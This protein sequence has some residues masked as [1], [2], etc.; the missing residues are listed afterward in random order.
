M[1]KI[2]RYKDWL[3]FGLI[4]LLGCGLRY[5]QYGQFPIAG[6]TLDEYAWS[7]L[8]ASL[9]EQHYPASWSAFHAYSQKQTGYFY[10][11][12]PIVA[13]SLDHPPLFAFLPGFFHAVTTDW[14]QI[15]SIIAIRFPMIGLGGLNLLLFCLISRRYLTSP[16]SYLAGVIY[17]VAPLVVFSSR[18]ALAENFLQTILLMFILLAGKNLV[19]KLPWLL[20]LLATVAVLTK[21]AGLILPLAIISWYLWQNQR[22]PVMYV[23][24]GIGLGLIIWLCYGLMI[25]APL[26]WAVQV[27]QGARDI[28]LTTLINRWLLHPALI[29]N[30]YF[31]GWWYLGWV[32]L[33][34]SIMGLIKNKTDRLYP[35]LTLTVAFLVWHTLFIMLSVGESTFH[36]WYDFTILPIIIWW[37]V[38]FLQLIWRSKT[39]LVW[40]LVWLLL[41]PGLRW[42][43]SFYLPLP[44]LSSGLT[45]LII[46]LGLLPFLV[47]KFTR[48]DLWAQT[49]MLL[50]LGLILVYSVLTVINMNDRIYSEFDT[51]YLPHR[52]N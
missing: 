7:T 52:F 41:L 11:G 46:G 24:A 31:D 48:R 51:F 42:T 20:T 18:L 38:Y 8:G 21:V 10:R 30:F 13:P 9:I 36:G 4:L 17:G 44:E 43:I 39:Y 47:A 19:K 45:R 34:A 14:W 12:W 50:L 1:L 27:S 35:L 33:F 16:W 49:A 5:Y 26:F 40:W 22:R 15:P 3:I 6:E 29:R 25:D 2:A 37:G 23:V 28:G 32:G